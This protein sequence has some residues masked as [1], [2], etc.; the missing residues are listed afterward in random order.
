MGKKMIG[1]LGAIGFVV[2]LF[3]TM[4]VVMYALLRKPGANNELSKYVLNHFEPDN[5][6]P[7]L[8]ELI[9]Y[10]KTAGRKIKYNIKR[11]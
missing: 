2:V 7:K 10:H 5:T 3:I 11:D 1:V 8:T 9:E 4:V 6:A